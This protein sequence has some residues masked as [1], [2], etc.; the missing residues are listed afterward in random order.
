MIDDKTFMKNH[1]QDQAKIRE[2]EDEHST[3][4]AG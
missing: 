1:T 2:A 3:T 4:R